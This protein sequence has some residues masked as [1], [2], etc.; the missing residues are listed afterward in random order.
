MAT[1]FSESFAGSGDAVGNDE[2]WTEW[3]ADIDRVSGVA[4]PQS[5]STCLAHNANVFTDADVDVYATM[6][7]PTTNSSGY[8]GIFGRGVTS[9]SA[10]YGGYFFHFVG[11]SFNQA[12]LHK[13]SGGSWTALDTQTYNKSTATD[14]ALQ[15]HLETGNIIG[16]H[17][18]TTVVSNANSDLTDDDYAGIKSDTDTNCTWDDFRVDDRVAAGGQP[19]M[20]RWGGVPGMN[21]YSGRNSW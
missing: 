10:E 9:G 7:W 20:R 14:Y 4:V 16:Y 8:Q 6:Q 11:G 17:G 21:Q 3:R 13:R 1:L 5:S 19:T 2:S 12:I 18:E 15:L